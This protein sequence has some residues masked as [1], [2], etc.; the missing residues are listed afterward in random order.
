MQYGAKAVEPPPGA[1]QEWRIFVDL[2]IAMRKPLFGAKGLNGF[3]KATR[4]VARLDAQA[5]AWSSVRTGS[6]GWWSR[7]AKVQRPQDQMARVMAHPHGM[8]L[9]PR[10]FGHFRDAL[11]TDDKKV[12]AAPPEFVARARELLAEPRPRRLQSYP[13]QL[14]NRRNR[15]SMNSWL[16]ELPGLHPSGKRNEVVIHPEDAAALGIA[17]GDRVRVFSPVGEIELAATVSD[18][19]RRGVVIVDHGWGSRVFDPRGGPQP[20]SYGVNR[21]LLVDGGPVDPLSQTS[22]LSSSTSASSASADRA[23][24]LR[25]RECDRD[26]LRPRARG[27][28]RAGRRR[29]DIA[30]RSL[31]AIRRRAHRPASPTTPA[32]R[33]GSAPRP[34]RPACRAPD[35]RA[36]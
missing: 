24:L 35:A 10:E 3:I 23:T 13:F 2:A 11:R 15:H 33:T 12:H 36:A 21:N 29:C 6:T 4:R 14:A 34:R 19:P 30:S 22:A 16:N 8:V 28:R 1:R 32:R 18:R 17:D 5:R 9:G 27:P 26:R 25:R 20:E 31:P 7:R